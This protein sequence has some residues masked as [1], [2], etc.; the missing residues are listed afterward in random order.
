MQS[1]TYGNG[2]VHTLTRNARGLPD[3]SLDAYGTTK[4]LDD[5]YDYDANGNVAAIS[6]GATGQNQRGNRTMAYD[7][8]NRLTAVQSPMYGT[9]GTA[10]GY[11]SLDNLVH[12][13]APG[14]DHYYCYDASNRLTNVKTGGCDTGA[15]VIGLGYDVQGNLAN[16][17][18]VAYTFDQGNRLRSVSS[19]ASAYV[20][21]GHG[22]RV[23]DTTGGARYSLYSM[24]G[25]LAFGQNNRETTQNWYISLNGSLVAVRERDTT[26]NVYT[27]IYQHTDALGS[28]VAVTNES[29]T[30]VKRNEYEPYGK[31]VGAA[32]A[33]GPGYTGH[34]S[35]AATGLVYM[36]QRYY[37]PGIGR[38]LS[39]DPVTA[40]DSGDIR[41]FNRYAYA[42][43]N[44]YKFDDPDGRCPTCI[45]GAI[46][47][48]VGALIGLGMEGYRQVRSGDFDGGALLVEGG[49][50][51][52]IGGV[53]GLTGGAAAAGGLTLGAQAA[54][55]GSV[56]L[57]VGAGAHAV[58]EVAK[59]NPAPSAGESIAVGYATAAGAIAG[60]TISP[61]TKSLTTTVI[62]A[63]SSHPVTSNSGRVFNTVNIPAQVVERPVVAEAANSVAG[64]AVEDMARRRLEED[65]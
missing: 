5:G 47:A 1:F 6:D 37:D 12:V 58:G 43:N 50:G 15:T 34:M 20:Y 16:K 17:N 54:A 8:L 32:M 27:T 11:D 4:V 14:R 35:D 18:G 45:T 53:I 28:P 29:R 3:R 62:P 41:F 51:A 44:P 23:R 56:A 39:V 42:F 52:V 10:Y 21:D 2:I 24:A 13:V 33:D 64:S 48:G 30:V 22:R 57:G 65:Q 40:Y 26:T 49:K 55:T 36:Q 9:T 25:Q 61:A 60:T 19:P 59:G 46:G 31:L 38:D 7:G 63:V